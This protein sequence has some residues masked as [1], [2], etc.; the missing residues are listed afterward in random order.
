MAGTER[1]RNGR[2]AL[3]NGKIKGR[4]FQRMLC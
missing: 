3:V 2:I 1:N 4:K